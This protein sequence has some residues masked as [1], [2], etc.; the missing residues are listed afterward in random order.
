MDIVDA[1]GARDGTTCLVGA[2]G[3][4]TTMAT[5][6]SRL[7]AAVV[8]AT[9]RIPIFDDWVAEVVVTEDPV[10]AV[11]DATEWP[12][13]VVP[14]RERDDRYLGY[15]RT[16][17]DRLADCGHPVVVKADGARMRRFKAGWQP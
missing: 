12:V 8:T 16:V 15:D 9:V 5:L 3:K 2:G 13:G 10:A 1:L 7:E 11:D 4:K 14:E 17:V 6:A